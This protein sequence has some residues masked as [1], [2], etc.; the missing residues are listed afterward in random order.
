MKQ[1]SVGRW[2]VAW[3][4]FLGW[5]FAASPGNAQE[6][7]SSDHTV[8]P[9]AAP[10]VEPREVLPGYW[11]GAL[12]RHHAP[13]FVDLRLETADN[14]AGFQGWVTIEEWGF[15]ESPVA[16]TV[17]GTSLRTSILGIPCELAIHAESAEMVG[18]VDMGDGVP[19]TL[20]WKRTPFAPRRW[21]RQESV[22]FSSSVEL[23]GSLVTPDGPGP[24]PAV[25]LVA[26]RSYGPRQGMMPFATLLARN[27][28]AALA[29]DGRGRGDSQGD[30][31]T[32]TERD[33]LDDVH[34]AFEFLLSRDDVKSD[35]IGLLGESTGGW[36]V[37]MVAQENQEVAFLVLIVGPAENLLEQQVHVIRYRMLWSDEDFS[38]EEI[39]AAEDYQRR[40]TEHLMRRGSYEDW[41]TELDAAKET[42][43]GGW[44]TTPASFDGPQYAFYANQPYDSTEALRATRIP[45]LAIYGGADFV[46]PPEVNVPKLREYL[47]AAGNT[48][49]E[50]LTFADANHSVFLPG[51]FVGEGEFPQRTY[52]WMKPAPGY[53]ESLASWVRARVEQ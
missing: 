7:T 1:S 43:W 31:Q 49:F 39:A 42:R 51:G 10:T 25:V 13:L 22:R 17:D 35:Q 3:P 14:S 24:F 29:F 6:A 12:V 38:E 4:L 45:L 30:P 44:V 2:L 26:G 48:D 11:R 33:R 20:C 41:K 28:I 27:G 21:F 16:V 47:T 5:C 52:R 50:I 9:E 18:T 34:A 8:H 19:T 53:F 23:A 40:L 15:F 46:V 32:M 36:I 37:P